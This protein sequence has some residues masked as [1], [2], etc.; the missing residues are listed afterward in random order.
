MADLHFQSVRELAR[1]IRR[2]ELSS[3]ELTDTFLDRIARLNPAIN[4]VITLDPERARA[5]AKRA[6]DALSGS[7]TTRLPPLHGIPMTVKDAYEVT[8]MRTTSGAK[9]WANHVPKQDAIAV[10]RLREAGAIIVGKTNTP[11]FCADYQSYNEIFG[12]THNPWDLARTPGGSSG[13]AAAALAAGLTPIELGSDIA[14]SIR[15]PAAFCGVLGHKPTYD[16]VPIR[17]HIPGPPGSLSAYDLAVAGP[18][19]RSADDLAYVLP[20]VAGPDPEH[21]KAYRLSLPPPR[22]ASLRGYR[23]AAWLEDPAFPV[24]APVA[25]VLQAA[26]AALRRAG[27][28]VTDKRP[29]FD[30]AEARAIYGRLFEPIITAGSPPKV[31]AQLEA[32]AAMSD[33]N[34]WVTSARNA[35]SRHSAW[36]AANEDRAKL[37]AKLARFFD[38]YD[39]LLCPTSIAAAFPH[40]HSRPQAMRKLV[41]NGAPQAYFDLMGWIS[42]ATTTHHPATVAPVGRTQAGLPVGIQIIGPYL[43]DLTSIDFAGRL[44]EVIGGFEPPPGY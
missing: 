19:A 2:R 23:V 22:A 40:D 5:E 34:P 1:R 14:G 15:V 31:V 12:T 39:V 18:M 21:A 7:S 11:A 30:L 44:G 29:E 3:L 8:G 28:Q 35:I 13:G 43:E 6:D 41:V 33:Q 37:K 38:D 36:L 25:E 32:V 17:G 24:D 16:L 10:Q 27:A 26:V 4:A 20:I 9:P 42:V